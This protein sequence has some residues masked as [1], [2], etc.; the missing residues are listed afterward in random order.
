MLEKLDLTVNF[1]GDLR[2]VKGLRANR[3][4]HELYL[5]GNPC[6]LFEGY[7]EYVVAT[8]PQLQKLDGVE[9]SRTERILATQELEGLE[10][11]IEAQA[12]AYL[13][14]QA[15]KAAKLAARQQ[16]KPGFDGSWCVCPSSPFCLTYLTCL[17]EP[18]Q[19]HA[20]TDSQP[21]T[22]AIQQPLFLCPSALN[23]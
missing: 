23:H 3:H 19:I 1:I 5:T 21:H 14:E 7:R 9:I 10:P 18:F 15:R 16:R 11:K 12:E 2:G 13:A 6:S 20:A 17:F 4:L 22:F 8:L